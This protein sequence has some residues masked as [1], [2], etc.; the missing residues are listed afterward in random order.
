MPR[1]LVRNTHVL[2]RRNALHFIDTWTEKENN[3]PAA[4][5]ARH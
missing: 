4:G 3:F 5:H 1:M 2:S